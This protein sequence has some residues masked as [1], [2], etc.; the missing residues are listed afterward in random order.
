MP[1][2]EC[3]TGSSPRVS[4][5]RELPGATLAEE[6]SGAHV[7][8]AWAFCWMMAK[9]GSPTLIPYNPEPPPSAAGASWPPSN[10]SQ[11]AAPF[12]A[13]PACAFCQHNFNH[14]CICP[15]RRRLQ[16]LAQ[17]CIN[18]F[19]AMDFCNSTCGTKARRILHP[20]PFRA[21]PACPLCQHTP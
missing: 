9:V 12:R 15:A 19:C 5:T 14:S 1:K 6:Q 18:Q 2:D 10:H 11:N 21:P 8:M 17:D 4:K 13:P 7:F 20:G 3:A 16:H